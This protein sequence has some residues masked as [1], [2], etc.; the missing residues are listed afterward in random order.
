MPTTYKPESRI[1]RINVNYAFG[2]QGVKKERS[3]KTGSE[4]ILK[5]T[6]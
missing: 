2:K 5:R 6:K 3:R 4:D 1:F